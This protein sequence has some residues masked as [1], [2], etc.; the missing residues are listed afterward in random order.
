MERTSAQFESLDRNKDQ[1]LSKSEV[2]SDETLSGQFAAADT[3]A[4]GYL[5]RTEF[6]SHWEGGKTRRERPY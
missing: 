4:D 5:S 1:R 3:D 2:Q 6:M